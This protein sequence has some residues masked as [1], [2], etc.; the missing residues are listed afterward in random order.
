M[1]RLHV[2]ILVTFNKIEQNRFYFHFSPRGEIFAARWW[3]RAVCPATLISVC[4]KRRAPRGDRRAVRA[5]RGVSGP[6]GARISFQLFHCNKCTINLFMP[7]SDMAGKRLLKKVVLM[8]LL[9]CGR[10]TTENHIFTVFTYLKSRTNFQLSHYGVSVRSNH[11][12]I[13][14][15]KQ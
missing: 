10:T 11:A 15:F 7:N 12:K 6:W 13:V 8:L 5:V 2:P 1:Y 9:F 3:P 4:S 14:I